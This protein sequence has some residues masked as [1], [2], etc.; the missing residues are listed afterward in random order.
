MIIEK[1][2][3]EKLVGIYAFANTPYYLYERLRKVAFVQNLTNN[4]G[5]STLVKEFNRL[6]S[7]E[8][9]SAY[10][11]SISYAMLVALTFLEYRVALNELE[12]LELS[13][14]EWGNNIRDIF[15]ANTKITNVIELT[16]NMT[17]EKL[18]KSENSST[19]IIGF[20]DWKVKKEL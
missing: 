1:L 17:K 6:T 14:L 16:V 2:I 9:M 18:E 19:N 12:K 8:N 13:R 4:I 5:T 3:I 11:I 10:N 20:Q 7:S 15:I